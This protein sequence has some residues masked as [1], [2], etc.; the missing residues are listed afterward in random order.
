MENLESATGKVA[1]VTGAGSGIGRAV[2]WRLANRGVAVAVLDCFEGKAQQ[3]SSEIR[4]AGGSALSLVVDVSRK[5]EVQGV[6]S[7]VLKE[8]EKLDAVINCA[9]IS[10]RV[11]AVELAEED[12]DRMMAVNLK[13]TFL[14]CQAALPHMIARRNGRV[15]NIASNYGVQ[16]AFQMAHY[17][18]SK[19][20]IVALTKSLALECAPYGITVN[21]VAPGPVDTPLVQRTSEQVRSWEVKIPLGRIATPEDVAGAVVFLAIGPSDYITG[22]IFH[23]NGGALMPW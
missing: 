17:A 18:A 2:A 19:G 13:G 1:I 23:V 7:R 6:F 14:C 4:K 9:G 10:N 16:G 11:P 12:W 21:A 20:G 5:V 8:W 22:Q 15:V 3:V